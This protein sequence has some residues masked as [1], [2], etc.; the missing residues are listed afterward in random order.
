MRLY[1]CTLCMFLAAVI[2]RGDCTGPQFGIN[3]ETQKVGVTFGEKAPALKKGDVVTI[4]IGSTTL[5]TK[6]Q[7][8]F[9]LPDDITKIDL[10]TP[11]GADFE[12]KTLIVGSELATDQAT[13]TYTDSSGKKTD[14]DVCLTGQISR[15]SESMHLG[16]AVAEKD[17]EGT[18]T[19]PGALRLQY[20]RSF[21]RFRPVREAGIPSMRNMQQELSVSL[22][23]TDQKGKGFVDDNRLLAGVF[24]PR[25]T[26]ANNNLNRVRVGAIGQTARTIHGGDHN[27]DLTLSIDGWLPFFQAVTLLSD[28][29]FRASPLR[30]TISAGRRWQNVSN[31]RSQGNVADGSI[32]YHAYLLNNYR[33]DLE[34]KT[35]LN[36]VSDR[37][38]ATP[39]TQHTWK[40][41]VNY[42]G[43]AASRFS[44]VASFESGHS[45]PVFT[46]LK[47][48]FLGI[49]MQNL[50]GSSEAK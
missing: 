25:M 24:S 10:G 43:S 22:D 28:S 27:A 47:Q 5:Q 31:V 12:G 46:K 11:F 20:A 35:L 42:S 14:V 49:G 1:I 26:F 32:L 30:F 38:A 29:T 36:D 19:R 45:G 16:P 4:A 50:F 7:S 48:Y 41:S 15:R 17:E 37:P 6:V 33:L 34:Y 3:A 23:T 8:V 44:G 13:M 18:D 40:V 39:R 2:L 9:A 21:L